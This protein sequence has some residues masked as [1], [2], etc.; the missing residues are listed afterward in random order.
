MQC[1][2][3]LLFCNSGFL[4]LLERAGARDRS[5]YILEKAGA[6]YWSNCVRRALNVAVSSCSLQA[7]GL[8][9]KR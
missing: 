3:Y 9:L 1:T 8:A 2:R 4:L 6:K 5:G 7:H